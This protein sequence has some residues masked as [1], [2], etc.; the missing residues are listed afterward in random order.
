MTYF[1]PSTIDEALE[2]LARDAATVVAGGTDFY[3]SLPQGDMPDVVLD[4]TG[5]KEMRGI[6]Q[7]AAGWRIGG[8]TT[9]A[10]IAHADLPP[11]FDTLKQAA[12][13]VGSVQIQNVATLAGNL[14]NA[15][16]AADGVPPLLSLDA[17]VELVSMSGARRVPLN[18]F[19]TGPRQTALAT[20]ELLAAVHIPCQPEGAT[21]AFVKLGSRKYLVISIAMV[22]VVLDVKAG[23][24]QAARVAVGACSPV[25]MR[26]N[27]LEN[28]LIGCA[29]EDLAIDPIHLAGLAPIDD[30]RADAGYRRDAVVTLC[31][32]ALA[33][34]AGVEA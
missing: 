13:E 8:A 5:V 14:C 23:R 24:I 21:S 30:V 2:F 19:I 4:L 15:S 34:A 1:S 16:P 31:Q 9:W 11:V 12:C 7:S 28:S 22:S 26:L 3:P 17:S 6:S 10:D 32:R 29:I 25:A 20:G 27:G 18:E 33:K